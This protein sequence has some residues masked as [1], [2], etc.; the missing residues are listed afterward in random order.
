MRLIDADDLV[1]RIMNSREG[2]RNDSSMFFKG[3][4]VAYTDILNMIYKSKTIM[5]MSN[6]NDYFKNIAKDKMEICACYHKIN[7]DRCECWGT[8]ERETCTCGGDP[9]KCDKY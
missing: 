7:G 2:I 6:D 5:P 1:V 3:I 9:M 8:K 4:L